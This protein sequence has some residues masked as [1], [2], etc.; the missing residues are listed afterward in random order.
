MGHLTEKKSAVQLGKSPVVSKYDLS[1]L[2]IL[3]C[4]AAPL[5]KEHVD[6]LQ[7]R[8]PALVRQG[9]GSTESTAGCVYQKAGVSPAGNYFLLFA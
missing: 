7:S 3:G 5:S 9:Y 1:T 6:A 8:I 2:R 4:G